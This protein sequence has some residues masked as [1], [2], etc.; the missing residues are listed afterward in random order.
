MNAR[1]EEGMTREAGHRGR[2]SRILVGAGI[3]L[4]AVSLINGFLIHG[5]AIPRL[6]LSAHLV[7][8]IGSSLLLGLGAYW[9]RLNLADRWSR[10]GT[11]LAL[12]GFIGAWLVYLVAAVLG[13]GEMFPLVSGGAAGPPLAEHVLGLSLLVVFLAFV[14]LVAV[15]LTGLRGANDLP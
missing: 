7:G 13:A 12:G 11:T 4:F 8:L 1:R 3:L 5:M 2:H 6:A 14:G 10:V 9:P 15:V